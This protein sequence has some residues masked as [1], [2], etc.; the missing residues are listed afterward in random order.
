M[1]LL[2]LLVLL[3]SPL[4]AE[5][6]AKLVNKLK[7]AI[8]NLEISVQHGI[9]SESPGRRRGTGFIVDA[10]R[11]IIATNRHIAGTSASR[12]KVV[13]EDGASAEAK[14]WHYDAWHDFAFL[15]INKEE[16]P[17]NLQ[18]VKLGDSWQLKE[19]DDVLLIGNNDA[20]EY[21]VKFG[22]TA[23][24]YLVRG[25]R[26]SAT[27]QT[28]FDRAG[29]SSGSPVFNR[30][31]EV[32]GIHF[33]GSA[34]T[35]FE[36]RVEYLKDAL[37]QLLETGNVRRGDAGIELDVMLISD[38]EKHFHLPSDMGDSVRA[39][40]KDI[41]RVAFIQHTVPTT[42]AAEL[43]QAGDIVLQVAGQ[44]IGDNIY[45]FDRL[46]D[47][48]VGGNIDLTIVRNG[49]THQ[50]RIPVSDTETDKTRT[51]ALFAGA[52]LH[53]LSKHQRLRLNVE[54]KGVFL[55][56]A[57]KGSSLAGLGREGSHTKF[58]LLIEGVNGVKTPDL[59]S[60][61]AAVK[62]LKDGDHIYMMV[63]DR[64]VTQS[65]SDSRPVRLDLKYYPLRV[66]DWNGAASDWVERDKS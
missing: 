44:P 21:S 41:K 45:L 39:L 17:A 22:K 10:E 54:T 6:P 64:W 7:P 43:L 38:A 59:K 9:N 14:P 28:T 2:L 62:D 53:D 25:M 23:N 61:L 1:N 32:I 33:A 47:E 4:S 29:G 5:I 49:R 13:F 55:S 57:E 15:K 60:F 46:V 3:T 65:S 35:S 11:G 31:G 48:R 24:L 19:Q 66:F 50:V 16:K 34:S 18:A 63:Q 36:M 20:Q 51:F 52:A 42:K 12:I 40:R 58:L 8:V 56:Q 27:L 26:H 30:K 37:K